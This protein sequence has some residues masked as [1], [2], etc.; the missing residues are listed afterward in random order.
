MHTTHFRNL[1]H[2]RWQK[3]IVGALLLGQAILFSANAQTSSYYR[4]HLEHYDDKPV[5]Y[6]FLFALPVTRFGIVHSNTFLTQDT[7]NRITA[8]ATAGFRMGFVVNG[9]L[10]D[11]W[12]I[13]TTPSVSLYDRQVRYEFAKGST[14]SELREA[15]WIEIPVLFKYKSQRRM[16]TRMYMLGGM[17][18]GFETNV[19]KRLRQGSDFLNTRGS[20]L[21]V[22]Y[23]FGLEQFLAYTKFSPEIRFSHGIV[24]L[25]RANDLNTVSNGIRRLTSHSVTIYLMFE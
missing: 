25:F 18:F 1:L 13:R 14:R 20:D 10:N 8:P 23:G 22:D 6:G 7:L 4:K 17:T 3:V 11:S 2:L 21:T 12:D 9:Y 16:N 5:H 15:T 19:R 24:N